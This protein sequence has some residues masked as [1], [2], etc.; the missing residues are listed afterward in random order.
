M[1]TAWRMKYLGQ[2]RS[3]RRE[4]HVR[5]SVIKEQHAAFVE[6][7]REGRKREREREREG[8]NGGAE[9]HVLPLKVAAAVED[10]MP[11][12]R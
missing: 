2:S 3:A 8:N 6:R 11:P 5:T 1:G 9:C 12:L 7:A 4:C 10:A